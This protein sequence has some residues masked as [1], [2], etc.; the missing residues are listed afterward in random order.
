MISK[1][2]SLLPIYCITI[3]HQ[4]SPD[5]QFHLSLHGKTSFRAIILRPFHPIESSTMKESDALKRAQ[6][7]DKRDTPPKKTGN[8]Y[9]PAFAISEQ[10][11]LIAARESA[12]AKIVV[13]IDGNDLMLFINFTWRSGR[14]HLV[15]KRNTE[16]PRRF[17][18][19]DRFITYMRESIPNIH[20]I[21]VEVQF[22]SPH[23]S[24]L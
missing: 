7:G 13:G 3:H 4:G 6:G 21:P 14:F 16:E 8:T 20:L 23:H 12:I 22:L 1:S 2:S 5:K 18:S 10:D 24:I 9:D 17:K 19:A 15:T 11:I